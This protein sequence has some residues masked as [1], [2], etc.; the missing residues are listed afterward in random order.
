M[1]RAWLLLLLLIPYWS[2]AQD[3]FRQLLRAAYDSSVLQQYAP[4]IMLLQKA[5]ALKGID[6]GFNESVYLYLGNNYEAMGKTDSGIYYYGEAIRYFERKQDKASLAFIYN[7]LGMAE[8]NVMKRYARAVFYF[9]QQALHAEYLQD[10]INLF[11]CYNN[12]GI[13]FKQS[14]QYDSA[15]FWFNKVID[16]P[17]PQNLSVNHALLFTGDT[18]SL[19]KQYEYAHDFYNRAITGFLAVNDTSFILDA[20]I[21]QGDCFMQQERYKESLQ[22]L[23]QAI[24]HLQPATSLNSRRVLYHNLAYVYS[25]TGDDARAF[26][27]K[28][29]ESQLKDSINTAGISQAVADAEAKYEVR[30]HQDSLMIGRQALALSEALTVQTQR[31]LLVAITL[32]I[33][34]ALIAFLAF[35]NALVRKKANSVLAAEKQKV[36]TLAGALQ[37]ANQTKTKLFSVISHDLRSPISSLYALLKMDEIKTASHQ[38][39]P[40]VSGQVTQLLDTLEDLLHWSKSQMEQLVM[41][42]ALL[43]LSTLINDLIRLYTDT[44]AIKK[45]QLIYN[46]QGP[47]MLHTD[48]EALKTILRNAFTNALHHAPEGSAITINAGNK[49]SGVLFTIT[50]EATEATYTLMK[51]R[52]LTSSLSAGPHGLG[53]LLMQEFTERL[54]GTIDLYFADGQLTVALFIP[55]MPK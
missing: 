32:I 49:E 20:Y 9:R 13:A 26:F 8:I 24:H 4:A 17:S 52:Q 47:L 19:L 36:E 54:Q 33:A 23:Q 16:A 51:N 35:R 55:S 40:L 28:D 46:T 7:R 44:A 34:M 30:R 3:S 39:K 43:E 50:N 37:E 1:M 41:K 42:P 14:G 10:S 15:L 22:S 53:F 29:R 31:N 45:M 12:I 27:Y 11:D 25:H 48:E 21:N 38:N 18:Y 2:A 6:T 5:R